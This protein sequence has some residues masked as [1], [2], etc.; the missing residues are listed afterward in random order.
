MNI[1]S[2]GSSL[3]HIFKNFNKQKG[4]LDFNHI[5]EGIPLI[6]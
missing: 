5:T 2:T 3:K 4:N 6:E 1:P